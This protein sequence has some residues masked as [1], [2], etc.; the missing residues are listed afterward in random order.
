MLL[1]HC[2]LSFAL[3]PFLRTGL[4]CAT[5]SSRLKRKF[6]SFKLLNMFVFISACEHVSNSTCVEIR[7][8]IEE[9][10]LFLP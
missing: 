10:V 5:F 9:L 7:G 3:L 4:L 8:Q 6:I 1:V 2:A